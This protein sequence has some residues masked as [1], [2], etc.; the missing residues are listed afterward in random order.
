ML[1]KTICVYCGSRTGANPLY[2]QQAKEIALQIA[3][4]NLTLVY[5]GGN[6][7]LMGIVANTILENGGKAIGVIPEQLAGRELAHRN[8]TQLLVVPSMHL[9]KAKME[10][11]A[12][13]FVAL[14]GGWGTLDEIC[15]IATWRQLA[16]HSK[17]YGLFNVD[18][19]FD[20]LAQQIQRGVKEG[21]IKDTEAA[22]LIVNADP[23]ALLDRLEHEAAH[24]KKSAYLDTLRGSIGNS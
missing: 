7:G 9:R 5:G 13:M 6:V 4:R 8:L 11:L 15:E 17:P 2:A 22:N 16:L 1:K 19:Y 3:A 20:G 21:F 14:P 18:G 24:P 23:T 12:S 10:E